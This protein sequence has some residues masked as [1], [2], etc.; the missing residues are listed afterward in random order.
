MA[1]KI[2]SVTDVNHYIGRLIDSDSILRRVSVAGEIS[3][4]TVAASG[5]CYFSLKDEGSEIRC[6]LWSSSARRLSFKLKNGLSVTV[7]G[8]VQV[9]GQ[10]GTYSIILTGIKPAG[11][12]TLY[13]IYLDRIKELE[14]KGY[15]SPH[16]KQPLP[17]VIHTVGVVTSE[18]GAVIHDIITTIK[19]RNP[20]IEILLAPALVQGEGA[21][22]SIAEGIRRLNEDATSDVIIVG[23]GGGSIEDLW[24]FNELEVAEALYTSR[25]PVISAVG[26]ET[27]TTIAD[28]V[29]DMR[30]P[31]PTA[32]AEFV[33]L[34]MTE[35]RDRLDALSGFMSA[36]VVE[37][38]N[39]A[40][41]RLTT[42]ERFITRSSPE[43]RL[44]Q[45]R[46]RV[47]DFDRR[48]QAAERA[49][50]SALKNRLDTLSARLK[51]LDPAYLL[52]R[53]Y[54]IVTDSAG[55]VVTSAAQ[56]RAAGALVLRFGDGDVSAE[57]KG[58]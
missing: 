2:L 34:G 15:F 45:A 46:L 4:L 39:T 52:G 47:D 56:A 19:R 31:T 41:Q 49:R 12:G 5:H 21:G 35:I 17:E 37:L 7:T 10:R 50:L 20:L 57:V 44:T 38:Y 18:T 3:N 16:R 25:I 27:D 53:G 9:Y 33:S 24:A 51:L 36:R 22:A 8:S 58:E 29:A 26:H 54:T 11:T 28:F 13:Q 48:L 32:A 23:R 30:A 43:R 40:L 1:G 6:I 55:S 42:T 14:E